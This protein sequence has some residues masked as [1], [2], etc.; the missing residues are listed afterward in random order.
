MKFILKYF[1]KLTPAELHD[2][3]QL[4][5][6]VFQLEQDC[7]YKDIDGKDPKCWHLL[8]F[9]HQELVAYARLVPPGVSYEG[10][11][12]IGRV[13]SS[14]QYR[15]EGYGRI[16]MQE[17]I[18]K[19]QQLFPGIPIKISAQSY[20]QKFYHGFGFK[21]SSEPYLEDNIPHMEMILS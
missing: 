17:A 12:S 19:T 16:L 8:Y 6:E 20:L 14:P 15:K 7:L 11:S 18:D 1:D 4:R 21:V 3:L 2:L 13:V 9:H 5:E 10:Y